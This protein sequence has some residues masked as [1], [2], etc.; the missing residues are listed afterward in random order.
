MN[1]ARSWRRRIV[2]HYFC[3]CNRNAIFVVLKFYD[4]SLPYYFEEHSVLL[5]AQTVSNVL[6][7]GEMMNTDAEGTTRPGLRTDTT[8]TGVMKTTTTTAVTIA[9]AIDRTLLVG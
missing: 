7:T 6:V 3:S 5:Q 8:G 2:P 9:I 4:V 1:L